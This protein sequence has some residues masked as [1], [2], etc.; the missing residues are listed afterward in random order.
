M[1]SYEG[2]K[3]K[4]R[5]VV[6]LFV[7]YRIKFRLEYPVKWGVISVAKVRVWWKMSGKPKSSE[8]R[9]TASLSIRC[10]VTPQ[11]IDFTNS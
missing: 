6:T 1:N 10:P 2:K 3:K 7:A 4:R 8:H 5:K 9:E 11:H